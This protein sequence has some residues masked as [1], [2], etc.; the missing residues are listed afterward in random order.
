MITA[1]DTNVILDVLLR[2]PTFGER[3]AATLRACLME[4]SLIACEV[5]WAELRPAL[6]NDRALPQRWKRP[7]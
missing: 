2:D 7:K 3:S 1:V 6:A 5:V 4:G